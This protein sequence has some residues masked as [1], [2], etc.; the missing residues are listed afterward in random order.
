MFIPIKLH[1]VDLSADMLLLTSFTSHSNKLWKRDIQYIYGIRYI[2]TALQFDDE[3]FFLTERRWPWP[4]SLFSSGTQP[5]NRVSGCSAFP[6]LE[7]SLL[8]TPKARQMGRKAAPQ[9]FPRSLNTGK[10]K[11]FS[12]FLNLCF[13]SNKVASNTFWFFFNVPGL[14]FIHGRWDIHIA[15]LQ[16]T[17]KNLKKKTQ[18]KK[19]MLTLGLQRRSRISNSKGWWLMSHH[20][21]LS[22]SFFVNAQMTHCF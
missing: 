20:K 19:N 14:W 22:L 6:P 18:N 11:H 12:L 2:Q 1:H 13:I 16:K 8:N 4:D 17:C 5:E 9:P 3:V 21:D 15:Q 7:S 10:Q